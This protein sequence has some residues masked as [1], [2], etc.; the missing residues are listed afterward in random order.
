MPIVHIHVTRGR[1]LSQREA[2]M[3]G[4][5]AALV[6]AFRIPAQDA[7]QILH[8]HEPE[9]FGSTKGPLF[10]V[11]EILAFAGRSLEAK[12]ALYAAIARNLERDAGTPADS[13]MITLL[14]APLENWGIRGGRAA[15]DV[16]LG[17]TP[18]V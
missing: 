3:Q 2:L 7:H 6:E 1:P 15:C 8:E 11:V 14:E 9:N 16:S 12:R 4:V 13:L 17:F 18:N 10:T 5:H